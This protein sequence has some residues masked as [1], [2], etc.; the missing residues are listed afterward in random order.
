[1]IG[2]IGQDLQACLS[3]QEK[4][5]QLRKDALLRHGRRLCD[6][7]YANAYDGPSPEVIGAIR[8]ALDAPGIL[9]LQ[10]TPYGG[11][12]ITRRLVA[13]SL[14]QSHGVHFNWRDIVM[15]PGAMAALNVLF[16]AVQ[17]GEWADE[18]IVVTP[19]WLDYPLYLSHLHIR[20]I[21]VPVESSSLRLDLDRIKQAIGPRTRAVILSQ[22]ANPTGVLYTDEELRQLA[23][24]L[25]SA[26]DEILLISD[27]CHRDVLFG[28][29]AFVSPSKHYDSTCIVYSFGKSH[30][31]QGQRIGYVAVSPRMKDGDNVRVL[32]ERLCRIM[33][34][35]TPTALMQ[36][37]VR[38]MLGIQPDLSRIAVRRARVVSELVASGYML[39]PSEATFF[40]YPQA[41][42][43]DD[44]AFVE[45]LSAQG[46]M[47]LP[48]SMFHHSGYFRMSLT[49]TD[50][51]FDRALPV[52]QASIEQCRQPTSQPAF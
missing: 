30:F 52:L 38:N 50:E 2:R 41:P 31:I 35:C 43:L 10:Y 5:E 18:V 46:V 32:L 23:V 3:A 8:Q 42:G 48:S 33:G 21:F 11:S 39:A 40:L 22:P 37:A 6:L 47:V 51:M 29:R 15:T 16:R 26:A 45:E 19:C 1:M 27:E 49:A 17:T 13:Q 14:S 36:L 44:F 24:L 9:D 25:R 12:T 28:D 7:S 20:P 4:F 34:F